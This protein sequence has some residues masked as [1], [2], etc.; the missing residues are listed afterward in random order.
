MIV[1]A[2]EFSEN[3]WVRF[4]FF[5]GTLKYKTIF[6]KNNIFPLSWFLCSSFVIIRWP[7]LSVFFNAFAYF[8]LFSVPMFRVN[9]YTAKE[10]EDELVTIMYFFWRSLFVL[11]Q[12]PVWWRFCWCESLFFILMCSICA[13]VNTVVIR[14][15]WNG[16]RWGSTTHL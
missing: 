7:F 10:G 16:K 14:F 6:S 13:S 2:A 8:T 9:V 11:L 15:C 1:V 3:G 12:S 5:E 4:Y